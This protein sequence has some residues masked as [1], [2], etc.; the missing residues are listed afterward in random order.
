MQISLLSLPLS[1]GRD[2]VLA[3]QKARQLAGLLG[4][5]AADQTLIAAAAAEMADQ[6]LRTSKESELVAEVAGNRLLVRAGTSRRLQ[7]SRHLPARGAEFSTEDIAWIMR[8]LGRQRFRP[9]EEF[10]RQ[11][12][13]LLR[14]LAEL[15]ALRR[16][17]G[18]AISAA[19]SSEAA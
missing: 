5:S 18:G 9:L 12:Q 14:A 4:Y 15:S 3:K 10:R 2:V 7:L 17:L 19:S 6:A 13:E 1:R 8:Q 11:N 16:S